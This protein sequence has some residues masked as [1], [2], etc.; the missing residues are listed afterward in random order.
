MKVLITPQ[1]GQPVSALMSA[2]QALDMAQ[3]LVAAAQTARRL[4]H[5]PDVV[6]HG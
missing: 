6:G 5:G 3:A 1:A 4:S 2:D